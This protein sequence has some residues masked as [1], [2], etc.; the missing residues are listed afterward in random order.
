MFSVTDKPMI[1]NS[2]VST[3]IDWL[4]TRTGLANLWHAFPKWHE[5]RFSRH[6]AF[7]V[8]PNFL[9]FITPTSVSILRRKRVHVHI[10]PVYDLPLL[11]NYTASEVFYTTRELCEM[12][13][14]YLSMK[15]WPG[16]DQANV[17]HWKN[18]Y[19][20]LFKQ[21]VTVAS[22]TSKLSSL[23]HFSTKASLEI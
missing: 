6:A 22:V 11:P 20:T 9:L 1:R 16:C 23:T 10:D 13:T 21:E 14:G 3:I 4:W 8:V 17:W 15:R 2:S 7:T 19:N 18:F 5:E 12:L